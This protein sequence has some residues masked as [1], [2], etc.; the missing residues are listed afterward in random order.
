[1]SSTPLSVI[2]VILH[3]T[4]SCA[5]QAANPLPSPQPEEPFFQ[6]VKS[7]QPSQR[8][9]APENAPH[10]DID[11]LSSW[12]SPNGLVLVEPGSKRGKHFTPQEISNALASRKGPVF[13]V[14]AHMSF[15]LSHRLPQ[16]SRLWLEER[17]SARVGCISTF[18]EVSFSQVN[19]LPVVV[20]IE[21]INPGE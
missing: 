15:L 13:K 9:F 5:L 2:S 6:L 10:W 21:D 12:V 3:C 4:W 14:F 18:Y 7:T 19:K 17:R 16:Y 8:K 20:K 1:M 11:K